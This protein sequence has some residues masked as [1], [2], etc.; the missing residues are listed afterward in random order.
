VLKRDH[1]ESCKTLYPQA[2]VLKRDHTKRQPS[3]CRLLFIEK[4]LPYISR[5]K[6]SMNPFRL[7]LSFFLLSQ[8]IGLAQTYFIKND[9]II[10]DSI[11]G[12]SIKTVAITANSL[13]SSIIQHENSSFYDNMRLQTDITLKQYGVNNIA[14]LRLRGLSAEQTVVTWNDM[15]LNS[16]MLGQTDISLLP[17]VGWSAVALSETA[18]GGNLSLQSNT[19]T[20]AQ[21]ISIQYNTAQ[22]L[23]ANVSFGVKPNKKNGIQQQSYFCF[24][25][26][27]DQ[28]K[29]P[30]LP[31]GKQASVS[32]LP[33]AAQTNYGALLNHR[34]VLQDSSE[35]ALSSWT[36]YSLRDLPPTLS[37]F[38][39][40][41]ISRKS[42]LDAAQRTTL[43]YTFLEKKARLTLGHSYEILDYTDSTTLLFAQSK[44]NRFFLGGN[45]NIAP[46]PEK[47]R[48]WG[49][50]THLNYMYD[51]A[52]TS[53]YS[54]KQQVCGS[55][56]NTVRFRPNT[57]WQA[58]LAH[59][60]T[61]YNA[62]LFFDA[63]QYS[64]GF[65]WYKNF[66]R[67]SHGSSHS[68]SMDAHITHERKRRLPTLNER[69]WQPGGKPDLQ[70]E[71]IEGTDFTL[72][73]EYKIRANLPL[74]LSVKAFF[75]NNDAH[76]QWLPENGVFAPQN[77]G[78]VR[79]EGASFSANIR[80]K[81]LVIKDLYSDFK[82]NYNFTNTN[83][84]DNAA[85]KTVQSI[86]IPKHQ[87]N[88]FWAIGFHQIHLFAQ[89]NYIGLRN[90]TPDASAFLMPYV[91][92]DNGI[93]S[94]F[95]TK[96]SGNFTLF[97]QV[98]NLANTNY[99]I[100]KNYAQ[101]LRNLQIGLRFDR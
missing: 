39:D 82:I 58:W 17:S 99:E 73:F 30:F 75:I 29:F 27:N 8:N 14:N 53:A 49:L 94:V 60:N 41:K 74:S 80:Y 10:S 84:L 83:N 6:L 89:A 100:T 13:K 9:T 101:P 71:T 40:D 51:N 25:G 76:I 23:D 77:V 15:P 93:S 85:C 46:K 5:N 61:T 36:N 2:Q 44:A 72:N 43:A 38:D 65:D 79:S 81:N 59:Q 7:V 48:F 69:F 78:R 22:N 28:N 97:V 34:V 96:K 87:A 64:G 91:L 16:P 18:T 45:L 37:D 70:P 92:L 54:N 56:K 26:K 3:G 4:F 19:K 11:R 1:T 68:S 98:N 50:E 67:S 55:L 47:K 88:V 33:H 32:F 20:T 57:H 24:Y 42:Q 52:F 35:F 31:Y 12:D 21:H 62:T 63:A 86:Y 95:T 90:T 66:R